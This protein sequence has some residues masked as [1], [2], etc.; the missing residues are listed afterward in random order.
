MLSGLTAD[1]LDAP[2]A[3]GFPIPDGTAIDALAFLAQHDSYHLGQVSFL[4][5]QL[6][7]PP[8][9]YDRAAEGTVPQ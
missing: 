4:R 6:G 8:M 9:T 2:T 1:D 7:L 3:Q 5:R